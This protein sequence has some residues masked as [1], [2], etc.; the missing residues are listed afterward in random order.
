MSLLES[1]ATALQL[2]STTSRR[3]LEPPPKESGVRRMAAR[4][5][6]RSARGFME[7]ALTLLAMASLVDAQMDVMI[8]DNVEICSTLTIT[9]DVSSGS[10][11]WTLLIAPVNWLPVTVTIPASYM[12]SSAQTWSYNWSVPDYSDT[13]QVIAAV[14]DSSGKHSGVSAITAISSGSGSCAAPSEDLDFVWYGPTASPRTCGSW[15]IQWAEDKGNS[16][17]VDPIQFSVLPEGGTPVT[18]RADKGDT[19]WKMPVDWVQGTKLIIAAF[20][21]GSSGTGG[22]GDIYTVGRNAEDCDTGSGS[23]TAGL[24]AAST[25]ASAVSTTSTSSSHKSST[26]SSDGHRTSTSSQHRTS[27]AATASPSGSVGGSSSSTSSDADAAVS[28]TSKST[29]SATV[30]A[31]A[32]AGAICAVVLIGLAFWWFRRRQAKSERPDALANLG[33]SKGHWPGLVNVVPWTNME[34][35]EKDRSGGKGHYIDGEVTVVTVGEDPAS[36]SPRASLDPPE[37]K[38]RVARGHSS[39]PPNDPHL[40]SANAAGSSALNTGHVS[41]L[42]LSSRNAFFAAQ[43]NAVLPSN[44]QQQQQA[45]QHFTQSPV[46]HTQYS[47]LPKPAMDKVVPDAMLFPPPPVRAAMMQSPKLGSTTSPGDSHGGAATSQT[48][49]SGAETGTVVTT[50]PPRARQGHG[51]HPSSSTSRAAPLRFG[52]SPP[53]AAW[54]GPNPAQGG[55]TG[56]LTYQPPPPQIDKL[57]NGA[58][59]HILTEEQIAQLGGGERLPDAIPLS[60]EFNGRGGMSQMPSSTTLPYL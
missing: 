28:S 49:R 43:D 29:S 59:A 13:P 33:N 52:P 46:K 47:P 21:A 19:S 51:H 22:V 32:A 4:T 40:P 16:G 15:K 39:R 60:G 35:D 8:S 3:Q 10:A 24:V 58:D 34:D 31:A 1:S 30:G 23:P 53:R 50:T 25:T 27:S 11:P 37:A 55:L 12:S 17:I 26:S 9:W 57:Y 20:D 14:S 44:D 38:Y 42:S 45:D 6:V 54:G 7:A 56:G 18:Y 2:I 41:T 48:M 5:A 36:K